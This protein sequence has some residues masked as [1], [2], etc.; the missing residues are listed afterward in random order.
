VEERRM[1]IRFALPD[2]PSLAAAAS[3]AGLALLDLF[4]DYDES[5]FEP[6]RSPFILAILRRSS[7][8]PAA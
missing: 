4:G 3:A 6:E 5:A 7:P 1:A 8:A 2:L